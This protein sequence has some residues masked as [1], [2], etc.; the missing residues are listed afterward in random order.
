M[1]QMVLLKSGDRLADERE[2][3]IS[4][5]CHDVELVLLWFMNGTLLA[6]SREM[7]SPPKK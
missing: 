6:G 5:E 3:R 7:C 4:V 1:S 2:V